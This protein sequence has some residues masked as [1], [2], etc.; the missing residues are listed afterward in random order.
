MAKRKKSPT[1]V[2]TG[3][4]RRRPPAVP[5]GRRIAHRRYT[6]RPP[7]GRPRAV[8]LEIGTPVRCARDWGC[9]VRITGL[10]EKVD[11]PIYGIDAVQALEVALMGAGKIISSSPQFRAGQIEKW[12]KPVKE[13]VALFLP[14]PMYMLQ[15]MLENFRAYLERLRTRGRVDDEWTRVVL[16]AMKETA[17]DLATLAAHLPIQRAISRND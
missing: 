17:A 14:L 4:S 1:G 10:P 12:G 16:L 3:G 13:P 9:R 5:F 6:W 8:V 11:R 7:V 2:R 15:G